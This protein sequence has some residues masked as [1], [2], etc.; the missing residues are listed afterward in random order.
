MTS[1]LT[2]LGKVFAMIGDLCLLSLLWL[3]L[4]AMASSRSYCFVSILRLRLD[5]MPSS[6]CD[7]FILMLYLLVV[8]MS[9]MESLHL[10][11]I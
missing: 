2:M 6:R 10:I 9:A 1:F 7:G 5:P 3:R 4:D 8:P 11:H